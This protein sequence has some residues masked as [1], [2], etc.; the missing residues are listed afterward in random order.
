M[1]KIKK[2]A[3]SG[4]G[5]INYKKFLLVSLLICSDCDKDIIASDVG[6]LGRMADAGVY[7][8]FDAKIRTI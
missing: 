1:K 6:T 4:S 8:N 5:Y 3:R 2:P 7:G